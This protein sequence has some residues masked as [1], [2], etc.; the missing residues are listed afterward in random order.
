MILVLVLCSILGQG[1]SSNDGSQEVEVDADGIVNE[2]PVDELRLEKFNMAANG[3]KTSKMVGPCDCHPMWAVCTSG[4][5]EDG[6]R[7]CAYTGKTCADICPGDLPWKSLYRA[8]VAKEAEIEAECGADPTAKW[9]PNT[10]GTEG[11]FAIAF[12]GGL[13]NFVATWHSWKANVVDV[14][15]GDDNVHT[16]FHVWHDEGTN[17]GQITTSK[18]RALAKGLPNTKGY[19][20]ERFEDHRK[21][22]HAQEPTF[23]PYNRTGESWMTPLDYGGDFPQSH[24]RGSPYVFGAG[25]SQLDR[26]SVV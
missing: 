4:W 23:P 6:A 1:S 26:K 14:S 7:G 8:S 20:E 18:G 9:G 25:F 15:G 22:L 24:L 17:T 11:P 19:V 13:R 16:Y 12:S 21:L 3:R 2:G 10:A 5:G